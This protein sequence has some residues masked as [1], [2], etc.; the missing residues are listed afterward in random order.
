MYLRMYVRLF[1]CMYVHIH[2]CIYVSIYVCINT[3]SN[4]FVKHQLSGV[5]DHH[6]NAEFYEE[7]EFEGPGALGSQK[8]PENIKKQN[9][10]SFLQN[11]IKIIFLWLPTHH[12]DAEFYEEF[13]FEGPGS[14]GSQKTIKNMKKQIFFHKFFKKKI[15][16]IVKKLCFLMVFWLPTDL[17]PSNSNSS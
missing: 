16:K 8:T 15:E 5:L 7:F 17:G 1:V 12:S 2:I 6:S 10:A 14:V 3:F 11:F 13:E 4:D 9:F